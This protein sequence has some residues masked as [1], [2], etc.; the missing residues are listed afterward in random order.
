MA[1]AFT[2][3]VSCEGRHSAAKSEKRPCPFLQKEN[4]RKEL[5]ERAVRISHFDSSRPNFA[6][7]LRFWE[8]QTPSWEC[9]KAMKAEL[10]RPSHKEKALKKSLKSTF[11]FK[12][13]FQH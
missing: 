1:L 6:T 8:H 4:K 9:S 2:R 5:R 3:G 13:V 11:L 7:L 10:G 12:L